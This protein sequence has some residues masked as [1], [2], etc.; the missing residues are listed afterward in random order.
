MKESEKGMAIEQ[1]LVPTV[2]EVIDI[3]DRT[4]DVKSFFVRNTDGSGLPFQVQPGQCV[5]GRKSRSIWSLPS[6]GWV[7]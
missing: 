1:P 6:N 2:V 4:P 5:P 7:S 3:V